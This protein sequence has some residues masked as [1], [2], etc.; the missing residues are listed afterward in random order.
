MRYFRLY[1]LGIIVSLAI[2]SCQRYKEIAFDPM[3][4][5]PSDEL[6]CL[7]MDLQGVVNSGIVIPSEKQNKEGFVFTFNGK[8][9]DYYKIYY[10]N[11]S[12]KFPDDGV[13]ANENFYGSW[14]DAGVG[15]KRIESD[16]LVT[17]SF[18]IVGNPR[19]EQKYYGSD[20][21]QKPYNEQSVASVIESI[22][23]SP[24]YYQ[25]VVEK[26]KSKGNS[27]EEQLAL[28][29]RWIINANKNKGDVNHRWKRNPRVGE[30][31]FMLVICDEQALKTIDERVVY[32]SKTD[33]NGDFLNPFGFF[34][35]NKNKDIKVVLSPKRLRTRAI[36]TPESGVFVDELKVKTMDYEISESEKVGSSEQLYENALFEQF[37]CQVS[38]QY[39]L[40]NIPVVKDVVS[41]DDAYTRAEYE[42]NKTRFD[43]SQ[44]M[45][46]Y[47]VESRILGTTLKVD[48][49]KNGIILVNPGNKGKDK[50]QKESTGVRTRVG[51]TYG[52]FRGKIKFPVMLNDE[53]IWNGLTNAFWLLNQENHEW[54]NR[55]PSKSGY[56]PRNEDTPNPSRLHDYFYS[57]IDIEIV[58]ASK[59]WPQGY[60]KEEVRDKKIEDATMNND[61]AYA[62]TNW[63]L[64]ATD[65][66]KFS[67]GIA[68]IPYEN[69]AYEAMRWSKLY[70]ALTIR[71]AISNEVFK[72]DYYYYEIDWRPTEIIWR[73]GPT[74]DDMTV[75]GY[76]NEDYTLIP[77][78]Q[79]TCI[80][81]QEYHY[82][83]WWKPIVFWQGLIPYNKTDIEGEIFE[84]VV[85]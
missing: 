80:M 50:L 83:E 82:S 20:I 44:L 64:A 46:D 10:Q 62:C 26:A 29:A 52:K 21:S 8:K 48:E 15:F 72:N 32:I 68:Q 30:Y 69:D 3:S 79:M 42:A 18:R 25:S 14:E 81:T 7:D 57:E 37:F 1:I 58:K 23:S 55:R 77:N 17:D 35:K 45:H 33:E 22:K 51:F 34:A 61:V 66:L 36:I 73:L 28:D 74:P 65:P 2:L 78:N 47:P 11:E 9:G 71:T 40:R 13:Y 38:K 43:S 16:G 63:D 84:I 59:Y 5:Y 31:S 76:M 12:Y 41:A 85:E 75:V 56:I 4:N 54:N 67:S 53:N 19:D 60:Y 39:T 24:K 6:V 70:K 49:E 27:I